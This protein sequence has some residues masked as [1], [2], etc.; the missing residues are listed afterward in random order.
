MRLTLLTFLLAAPVVGDVLYDA[1][2]IGD[3]SLSLVVRTTSKAAHCVSTLQIHR[4]P[5]TARISALNCKPSSALKS[6]FLDL[7]L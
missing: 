5:L 6:R 7:L 1:T 2:F 4:I 3:S